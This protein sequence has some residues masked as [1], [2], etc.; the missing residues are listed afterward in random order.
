MN[1]PIVLARVEPDERG[2]L[3]VLAPRIGWWSEPPQRGALLGAGSAIGR[4]TQLNRRYRL[5]LPEGAAGRVSGGL[6]R[7]RLTA[8]EH[9]Q[10]LF[11]LEPVS[12]GVGAGEIEG[13]PAAFGHPAGGELPAGA[14]VVVAPTDGVFYQRP[15]PDAPP[16][17]RPGQR[18][19]RG[20]PVGLVEVMKTF[21][22]IVYDGPG[23]PE[24][25]EV[26]ELR[27][28]D[29]REVRAG[30]ILVVLRAAGSLEGAGLPAPSDPAGA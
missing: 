4:L 18:I 23:V 13:D 30:E 8:V 24:E 6:P 7:H 16:F 22:Q 2:A 21:N 14:R 29:A 5:V 27:G 3:R 10:V 9:G 20:Q 19:R 1:E 25:A 12:A 28:G 26:V 15:A 17:V 11:M